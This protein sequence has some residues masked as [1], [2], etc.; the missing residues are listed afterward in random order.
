[1]KSRIVLFITAACGLL[2]TASI[3]LAQSTSAVE[4]GR[5]LVNGV[6]ACGNCHTPLDTSNRPV[7]ERELAGGRLFKDDAFTAYA[8]NLTPDPD[9]GLGRWSDAQIGKAIR[10]GVRPDG[11]IIGPPMAVDAYRGLA[12]DDL[13]AIIAYLR[14]IPPV[15]N[16]VAKSDYKPGVVP[17]SYGPPVGKIV[18]PS[19][20][21]LVRYGEYLAGP[22]GHCME[23]HSPRGA[24]RHPDYANRLGAG[25]NSFHGPWTVSVSRN[26]TPHESGLK[27]WTDAEVARAI[28]EGID[29]HGNRLKPPMGFGFYRNMAEDEMAAIIAYLRSLKAMPFAGGS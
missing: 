10:E 14:S 29:R 7:T 25:G 1:M 13:Q 21:D 26:L 19:K 11:S 17:A 3:T 8:A 6:A 23:C 4:R 24:N 12:D 20:L 9:T 5:A 16:A 27:N 18:A 2:S 28:R 15:K 22:V